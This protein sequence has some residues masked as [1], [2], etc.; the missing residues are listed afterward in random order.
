MPPVRIAHQAVHTPWDQKGMLMRTLMERSQGRELVL[1][2]GVKVLEDDGWALVL[3][4]PEEPLTH[5]WAEAPERVPGG[6]PGRR[7]RHAPPAP[8]ALTAGAA[9]GPRRS[10]GAR[11]LRRG[12]VGSGAMNV[13]DDLRYSS[14][15]E[16]ARVDGDR[17]R[18]GITDYAQDALGD[19]VF[20]DLPGPGADGRG[21]RTDRRGRVDQV[22]LGDLRPG[23]R[24]GRGRQHRADGRP[25]QLN[26]DPYGEGWICEI[27]P[28]DPSAV[29]GLLDAAGYRQ[30]TEG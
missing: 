21:R 18:V 8:P 15:H 24:R 29:D 12:R 23:G 13:P 26:A 2:D 28:V 6:G 25:E 5:V 19:V 3:P 10:R 22:R 4:D 7:V 27:V 1:V 16:W 17:I 11:R 30:L 9:R 20:V 14:D